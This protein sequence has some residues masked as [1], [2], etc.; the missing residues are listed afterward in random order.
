MIS[1]APLPPVQI[2]D[3]VMELTVI[4][5]SDLQQHR[6]L[7]GG[8]GLPW[9]VGP[10]KGSVQV[11]LAW[12]RPHAAA[13]LRCSFSRVCV[14]LQN[15]CFLTLTLLEEF[16]EPLWCVSAP[17]CLRMAPGSPACDYSGEHYL[18]ERRDA[19]GEAA[20]RLVWLS[21]QQQFFLVSL[22]VG[23]PLSKVNRLFSAAY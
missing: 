20:L 4:R 14:A 23:V 16:Q 18:L 8:V 22:V 7:S 17:V 3:G 10:L 2:R 1:A 19:E 13:R 5:S 15:C 12:L 21:E 6:A 9:G 11:P